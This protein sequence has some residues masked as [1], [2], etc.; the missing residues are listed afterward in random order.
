MLKRYAMCALWLAI[1]APSPLLARQRVVLPDNAHP[2]HYELKLEPDMAHATFKGHVKIDI[3]VARP[4]RSLTLN[5]AE[6]KFDRVALTDGSTPKTVQANAKNE[7]VTFTFAKTLPAGSCQLDIAY[8]G[9][10]HQ[11]ATG[12]FYLD[13][14]NQGKRQRALFTQLENS[15]ARRL[16][17]CW[18][19]PNQKATF[20][21]SA[22]V[23]KQLMAVSNMPQR[24]SDDGWVHFVT[25]P[26]MSSY[27]LF[28]G[29][30]DFE[31]VSRQV[32]GVDIGVVVKR[33]DKARAAYALDS[34]AQL[35]TYYNDY[36]G[37]K[38]PLPK[39]DL[40]AGPGSSQ[41]FSAMENW[42][43]LF[44]FERTLLFDPK[45]STQ[46]EKHTVFRVIAHEMA[47]QWFGDL[48]TMDWWDDLWL[49]EGFASWLEAKATDHF[50]P[51]WKQ[52]LYEV[53]NRQGAMQLDARRGSH[54]VIQSIDD[55]LQASQAFD[56]IT[57]TKGEAIIGML[58]SYAG[59]DAFRAGVRSYIRK[60]AYAN[61]VTDDLWKE[62]D[63]ASP[64]KVTEMAH[65][66]TRQAGV[67]LLRVQP[68][69]AVVNLSQ[70][71]FALDAA[72]AK[73][74]RWLLPLQVN[75]APLTLD[76]GA[77]VASAG[78]EVFNQGQ[79]G[80]FRTLYEGG[81]FGELLKKY[82][83]LA[84]IDK[85]GLLEDTWALGMAGTAPVESALNLLDRL[86]AQGD[87]VL[88]GA[89]VARFGSLDSLERDLSGR[90][91]LQAWGRGRVSPLAQ[92]LGWEPAPGEDDTTTSLRAH[93]LWTMA[94]L[95]DPV[96][97]A[98]ARQRFAA[99][100]K[101]PGDINPT[102]RQTLLSIVAYHAD[103]ATWEQLHGLA[104]KARTP[105]EKSELY[106][107]L[108]SPLDPKLAA[109]AL[110]IAFSSEVEPSMGPGMLSEVSDLHPEMAFT[111]AT[112][113]ESQL[114]ARLEPDSR[115]RYLPGD[116]KSVV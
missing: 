53:A 81:L 32:E 57:Y 61:A 105:L 11:H 83:A 110:N 107:L 58:E 36:F 115:Y 109:Q 54:P 114:N 14:V 18:D 20:S 65:Q 25:S 9:V 39:M 56:S 16:L 44:Y 71:R 88:L 33:G 51:E 112:T 1:A 22:H 92:R 37:Y 89:T 96:T 3:Q 74:Q 75:G 95:E 64:R 49:N 31:R 35:L 17:P 76:G 7:S 23:P 82:D 66:F 70:E 46:A 52:P 21:L 42:G 38:Y 90:K 6:L 55:V 77:M 34:S 106:H 68:F 86:P 63:A 29:L 100:L 108:A 15:D 91:A 47:H 30:G 43:A 85:L 45:T 79:H 26:K 19:E 72:S 41:F 84:T 24:G 94:Q 73:P 80:Y 87:D 4:T 103:A 104:R 98:E 62:L 69:G 78:S 40:I 12:L 102:V 13:Y 99:Y 67:P 113:H 111:Y 8:R 28:F 50:H 2:S 97:L 59:A 5:A 60:H 93:V 48:V 101:H 10:I 116:R 27:L